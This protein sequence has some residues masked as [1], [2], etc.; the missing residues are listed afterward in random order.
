MSYA[1]QDCSSEEAL[2]VYVAPENKCVRYHN[3]TQMVSTSYA[4]DVDGSGA[5]SVEDYDTEDCT[6]DFERTSSDASDCSPERDGSF[7]SLQCLSQ[8]PTPTTAP[9]LSADITAWIAVDNYGSD[10]TCKG[11]PVSSYATSYGLCVPS[12]SQDEDGNELFYLEVIDTPE[13]EDSTDVAV[14]TYYYS[15]AECTVE[16]G[17]PVDDTITLFNCDKDE[18]GSYVMSYFIEGADS[19]EVPFSGGYLNAVYDSP[20]CDAERKI[21]YVAASDG[22][23]SAEVDTE[24][25][26]LVSYIATC[27]MDGSGANMK[28]YSQPGCKG[29]AKSTEFLEATPCAPIDENDPGQG[30]YSL[31]CGVFSAPTPA[32]APV[33]RDISGWL[34]FQLFRGDGCQAGHEVS[35]EARSF[36]LCVS[37]YNSTDGSTINYVRQLSFDKSKRSEVK[38]VTVL[39]EDE[40]CNFAMDVAEEDRSSLVDS[41]PV[42]ACEKEENGLSSLTVYQPG[43]VPPKEPLRGGGYLVREFNTESC[44]WGSTVSISA[45]PASDLCLPTGDGV[46]A[47]G[48]EQGGIQSYSIKC[49]TDKGATISRYTNSD[50]SGP[51]KDSFLQTPEECVD[52]TSGDS[53]VFHSYTCSAE[54]PVEP[55]GPP[56]PAPSVMGIHAWISEDKFTSDSCTEIQ[57]SESY[58]VG[59]CKRSYNPHS[60]ALHYELRAAALSDEGKT[61]TVQTYYFDDEDCSLF[62]NEADE[63]ILENLGTCQDGGDGNYYR[64]TYHEG[65]V[66]P[67]DPFLGGVV[68]VDFTKAGCP[69]TTMTHVSYDPAN[70]MCVNSTSPSQDD[71]YSYFV[72]GSE[73]YTCS[74]DGGVEVRHYNETDCQGE[75]SVERM[76]ATACSSKAAEDGSEIHY[77]LQC[78]RGLGFPTKAPIIAPSAEVT[79]IDFVVTQVSLLQLP[80][81]LAVYHNTF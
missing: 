17:D 5:V 42:G 79:V 32:P 58:S 30:S 52:E 10:R 80:F 11:E 53:R 70:N 33:P 54:F 48:S 36:G 49:D 8:F 64:Q 65:S 56:V 19:P 74:S 41:I 22:E 27:E 59:L 62:R 25:N 73:A 47:D 39:Y 69:L 26:K 3:G 71:D 67:T 51:A 15:D 78:S 61:L 75:Y 20:Y 9:A 23:C 14:T 60:D 34:G 16:A 68:Q 21:E 13:T 81:T 77:S 43:P 12:D 72:T 40:D 50:C 4:C 2:F 28:S 45:Y 63:I 24:T 66:I 7:S 18:T 37:L 6:G 55:T 57:K 44:S 29:K 38:I 1:T 46:S 35:W 31:Q 76:R